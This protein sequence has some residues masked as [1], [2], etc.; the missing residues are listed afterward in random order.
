MFT[1]YSLQ[2]LH[3]YFGKYII[4]VYATLAVKQST[5]IRTERTGAVEDDVDAVVCE[6]RRGELVR[7]NRLVDK[8]VLEAPRQTEQYRD[9][10]CVI[11]CVS[12]DM[13]RVL[14]PMSWS[15]HS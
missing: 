14:S 12:V 10:G 8:L 7:M 4:G 1:V 2:H 5:R 9:N 15:I 11:V 13:C 3:L 6:W